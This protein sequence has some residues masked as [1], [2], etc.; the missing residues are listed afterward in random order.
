MATVTTMAQLS[1]NLRHYSFMMALDAL[2]DAFRVAISAMDGQL[3]QAHADMTAHSQSLATGGDDGAVYVN[4]H[5]SHDT[6]DLL[7]MGYSDASSAA[8]AIREAF[9][10]SLFH[11]WERSARSW[12]KCEE[13]SYAKL[14]KAL[15][16]ED[17][18]IHPKMATLNDL[19]NFLK[20][21]NKYK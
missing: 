7:A 10:I 18:P 16:T 3:L 1:F 11:L 8:R 9:V 19:S 6:A 14:A 15:R 2:I 21:G 20:H 4:D 17:I 12:V 13:Q 5:Y